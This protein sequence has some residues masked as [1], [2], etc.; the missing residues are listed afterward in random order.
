MICKNHTEKNGYPE[1]HA[2]CTR[3]SARGELAQ[4]TDLG[5]V[6][7]KGT[8]QPEIPKFDITKHQNGH[9]CIENIVIRLLN[10]VMLI[11][12]FF[13]SSVLMEHLTFK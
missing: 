12:A 8:C 1:E 3:E 2:A 10:H 9:F 4:S 6:H 11:E 13:S 7:H 5:L